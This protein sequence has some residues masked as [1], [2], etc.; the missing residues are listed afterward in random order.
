MWEDGEAEMRIGRFAF[1]IRKYG[2]KFKW[3][4]HPLLKSNEEQF[5]VFFVWIGWHFYACLRK[6][7]RLIDAD[8]FDKALEDAQI[9]C[10]RNGGNFRF[11]VLSTVRANL[12]NAPTVNVFTKLWNALYAEEDKFEKRYIGTPEHDNWFLVYRPWL[13]DG[14]G[15][16]IKVLSEIFVP[17]PPKEDKDD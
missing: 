12:K 2:R 9:Q 13:Q 15:I 10:K 11:G 7:P 14:F 16:A 3:F 6:R 1:G 4:Y 17:E 8:A 5:F